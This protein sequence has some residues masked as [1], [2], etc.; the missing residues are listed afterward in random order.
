VLRAQ[1]Q[2]KGLDLI[3]ILVM[4]VCFN[5]L[6]SMISTPAGRFSDKVGRKKMLVA[7]WVVYTLVYL[8]FGVCK[9]GFGSSLGCMFFMGFIMV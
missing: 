5:L 8:G 6:Y 2:G 1:N 9:S 3:G 4:L 7:G